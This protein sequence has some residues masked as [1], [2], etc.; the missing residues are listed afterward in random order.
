M[1]SL[2]TLPDPSTFLTSVSNW[3]SPFFDDLLPIAYLAI[4]FPL[5]GLIIYFLIQS[6]VK[7]VNKITSR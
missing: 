1:L 3:S 5:A 4:G 7:S 6:V 2:V